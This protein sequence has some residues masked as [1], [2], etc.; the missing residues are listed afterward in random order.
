[1]NYTIDASIFVAAVRDQEVQYQASLEFLDHA[2]TKV[3]L[4]YA[5]PWSWPN[6]LRQLPDPPA[7]SLWLKS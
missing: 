1:M 4:F 6:V 5:H 7:M 2:Q 3:Q